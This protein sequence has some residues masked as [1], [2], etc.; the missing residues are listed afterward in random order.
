[1]PETSNPWKKTGS[2]QIYQNDWISVREDSVIRPDG[3]P[4]IYGVIDTRI[5]TGVVALTEQNEVYLVGQFRYPTDQYSWEIV[6]GG[7]D[8]G[9]SPLNAVKREL[10]EEAGLI[11]EEWIQLGDEVH[12]S[13]CFSSEVCFLYLARGLST[14][15]SSPDATE[16]LQV[17]KVP[18]ARCLEML[19]S[20]EI[21]DAVS[22]IG[23]L[24]AERYLN[25]SGKGVGSHFS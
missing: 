11:A 23:L 18:F 1:M 10:I 3:S 6:E 16:I 19:D 21:K 17:K 7:A 20:G 5:A 15:E 13:N 25:K 12:L 2:R 24:R 14:T 8:H 4:G 22:I 9:E